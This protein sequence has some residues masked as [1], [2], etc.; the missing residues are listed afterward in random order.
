MGLLAN[1]LVPDA[2][3]RLPAENFDRE[4]GLEVLQQLAR[5]ARELPS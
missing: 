5:M 3:R 1:E 2:E 4:A